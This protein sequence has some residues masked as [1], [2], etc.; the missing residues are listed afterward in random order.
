Q[1]RPPSSVPHS[2]AIAG[3][4]LPSWSASR[5]PSTRLVR[6]SKS[7]ALWL[8]SQL[9]VSSSRLEIIPRIGSVISFALASPEA[10]PPSLPEPLLVPP[11]PVRTRTAVRA[12]ASSFDT[13]FFINFLLATCCYAQSSIFLPYYFFRMYRQADE[14]AIHSS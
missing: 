13:V 1:V 12:N 6:F 4:N 8:Y 9:K 14:K 10:S 2:S 11:Q 7:S 3:A 5:R